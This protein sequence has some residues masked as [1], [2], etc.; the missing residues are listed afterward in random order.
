MKVQ[1]LAELGR[2]LELEKSTIINPHW[3][4]LNSKDLGIFN[5][6]IGE[7]KRGFKVPYFAMY[8]F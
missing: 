4:F 7:L 1:T 5:E 2:L 3:C 8:V 6:F